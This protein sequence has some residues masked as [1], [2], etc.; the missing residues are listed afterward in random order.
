M[1][2]FDVKKGEKQNLF[3]IY[4]NATRREYNTRDNGNTV[5]FTVKPP[6]FSQDEVM[7]NVFYSELVKI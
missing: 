4:L 7:L 6:H 2:K 3:A 5:V 1:L